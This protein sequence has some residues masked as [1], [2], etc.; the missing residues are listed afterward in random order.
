MENLIKSF[1]E[2]GEEFF[3]DFRFIDDTNFEISSSQCEIKFDKNFVILSTE[4][5][6]TIVNLD[7]VTSFDISTK[8]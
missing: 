8:L 3:V 2:K 4:N 7:N 6:A 1:Q 5:L